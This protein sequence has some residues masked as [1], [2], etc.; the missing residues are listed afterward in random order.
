MNNFRVTR[1]FNKSTIKIRKFEKHLQ[2]SQRN[3]MKLCANEFHFVEIHKYI[4][5][6]NY[7]TQKFHKLNYEYAFEQFHE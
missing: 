6:V 5:V 1:T 3:K 7:I 4:I 2:F